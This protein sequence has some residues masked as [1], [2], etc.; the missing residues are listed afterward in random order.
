[1]EES[2]C[3]FEVLGVSKQA[4]DD[5]IKK[6]YRQSSF[7]NHPDR[8]RGD[9]TA[10]Q[11]IQR[12]N[13]AYSRIK[14]RVSRQKESF[15]GRM[16]GFPMAGGMPF[17]HVQSNDGSVPEEVLQMLAGLG[18]GQGFAMGGAPFHMDPL[19]R[20]LPP[21]DRKLQVSFQQAYSGCQLPL[22]I[23]RSV[24]SGPQRMTET[25]RIYVSVPPG[26]DENECILLRGQGNVCNHRKGDLRI[27]VAIAPDE[28]F[29]REGMDLRLSV[30]ISLTDALTGFQKEIQHVSGKSFRITNSKGIVVS[31]GYQK[32]MP[33][34]GMRR[35]AVVGDMLVEFNVTFPKRIQSGRSAELRALLE[36][37][38]V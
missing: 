35:G 32:R 23:E 28:N 19:S 29:V 18:M 5:Q 22:E 37:I 17:V 7:K 3:P 13:E 14:D 2:E 8:N 24:V 36:E 30:P 25:E 16:R 9:P 4:T 31:P 21:L 38:S 6:A 11:R 15:S 12:I 33:G 20:P 34:L 27:R 10:N 26:V 1:M